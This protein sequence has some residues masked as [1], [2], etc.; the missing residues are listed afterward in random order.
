[1]PDVDS[2]ITQLNLL[3]NKIKASKK[4]IADREWQPLYKQVCAAFR[5]AVPEQRVDIQI[6]LENREAQLSLFVAYL[7]QMTETA[8]KAARKDN[9]KVA[10]PALEEALTAD[11]II[12]GRFNVDA[13]QCIHKQ[14][15][16]AV[17]ETHYDMETFLRKLETPVPTYL[18]R[19]YKLH[20]DGQRSQAIR[21]LGRALQLDDNLYK[22]ETVANFASEL[23]GKS[24]KGA[25]MTLE[26]AYLRNLLI[27]TYEN[28]DQF[29][30]E[31][32]VARRVSQQQPAGRKGIGAGLVLAI[33]VGL[34]I[35][36]AAGY[37]LVFL[38]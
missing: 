9:Q 18:D 2:L 29:Q 15:E 24:P 38:R 13:L 21:T 7:N 1:M 5:E 17:A 4:R 30:R 36:G 35:F 26:D 11:A 19:A 25:I 34:V 28:P 23:T 27:E 10:I 33:L 8:L 12:D 14:L 16:A 3:Q 37:W 31:T 32:V 22:N 6:A 20:K